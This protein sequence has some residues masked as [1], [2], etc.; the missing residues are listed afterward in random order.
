MMVLKFKNKKIRIR[1]GVTIGMTTGVLAI[2]LATGGV[3][4]ILF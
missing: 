3:G 4:V 1:K 2:G